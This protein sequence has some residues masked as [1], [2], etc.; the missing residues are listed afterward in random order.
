MVD[1]VLDVE[2]SFGYGHL[3]ELNKGES[4][5]FLGLLASAEFEEGH[6]T[7][8]RKIGSQFGWIK[9]NYLPPA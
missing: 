5:G 9:G 1:E 4:Q 8:L 6:L 2:D 7:E 3:F